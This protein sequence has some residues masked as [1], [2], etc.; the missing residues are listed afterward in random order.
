M[1]SASVVNLLLQAVLALG[2]CRVC[3]HLVQRKVECCALLHGRLSPQ[4]P[5]MLMDNP[6]SRK[7]NV[8]PSAAAS[9]PAAQCTTC[10]TAAKLRA[11]ESS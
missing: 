5:T 11:S 4:L 8:A 2:Q 10:I 1:V 6:L 3:W 7:T 9:W